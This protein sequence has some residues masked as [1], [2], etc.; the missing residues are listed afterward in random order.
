[1]A[2]PLSCHALSLPFLLFS[3][4]SFCV[5]SKVILKCTLAPPFSFFVK[6]HR[7]IHF[8]TH[9]KVFHTSAFP[10]AAHKEPGTFFIG[11]YFTQHSSFSVKFFIFQKK[12]SRLRKV[13]FQNHVQTNF[14]YW[15]SPQI[16]KT[17]LPH[18]LF[19]ILLRCSSATPA[20]HT[21][22]IGDNLLILLFLQGSL[23][24][25]QLFSQLPSTNHSDTT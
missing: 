17:T 11:T 10:I 25:R 4:L 14:P 13:H 20:R 22:S 18:G 23:C 19:K 1:M 24:T 7:D 5:L 9:S 2:P 8:F 6:Y 12:A 21:V 16:F 15:L 3:F